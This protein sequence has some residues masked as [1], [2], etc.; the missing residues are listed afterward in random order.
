MLEDYY[1]QTGDAQLIKRYRPTIDAILDWFDRKSGAFGLIE[2]LGYWEFADWVEE[3]SDLDG[4]PPAAQVGPSTIHNLVY[5][6]ALQTA[7]RLNKVTGREAI[8]VEYHER[9]AEIINNVEKFCWSDQEG[10]YREGPN[11]NT[12]SQHAQVWAVLSGAAAGDRAKRVMEE[13]LERN[14]IAKCSFPLQFYMF[15]AM[16]KAG[17]YEETLALW[18]QW[19][20][21]LTLH[22]TTIPETPFRPRSDCHAWGALPLYEFTRGILGVS[23]LVPGWEKILIEPKCFYIKGLKGKVIT[24]KGIVQ[25]EF[26]K[27]EEVFRITGKAPQ[28]TE[29]VLRL[30]GNIEQVYPKGGVFDMIRYI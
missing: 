26:K 25:V 6:C 11:Y 10:L 16:E 5:A 17:L 14:N 9:A 27:E 30:P 15:R 28:D 20:E 21:L 4:V 22:L 13:A 23:P 8:S 3:W 2:K 7:S 1:W 18:G 19:K 29:L 24:P 12:Y